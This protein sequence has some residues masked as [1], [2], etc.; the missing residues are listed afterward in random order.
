MVAVPQIA[1]RIV[2]GLLA[3]GLH[4]PLEAD[5]L[6]DGVPLARLEVERVPGEPAGPALYRVRG[7]GTP[8][9]DSLP[10][11]PADLPGEAGGAALALPLRVEQS[12]IDATIFLA[13][14]LDPDG[15]QAF[16]VF[17]VRD[18]ASGLRSAGWTGETRVVLDAGGGEGPTEAV[19]L[20]RG[21]LVIVSVPTAGLLLIVSP[22]AR[23]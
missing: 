11:E 18:I 20:F 13:F 21:D 9:G 4:A 22:S 1:L 7:A 8:H 5:L 23:R 16:S 12:T 6:Q 14:A 15:R 17:T 10:A 19:F 3:V 2:F